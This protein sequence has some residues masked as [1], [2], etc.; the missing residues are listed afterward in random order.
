MWDEVERPVSNSLEYLRGIRFAL[1]DRDGVLNRKLPEGQFISKPGQLELLPDVSKAIRRLNDGG[2]RCLVLTNQRGIALGLYTE[3]DLEAIHKQL[4]SQ[5]GKRGARLDGFFHCPHDEGQCDCR[6]PK[7]GLLVQAFE[8]FPSA[9]RTNSVLIGDSLPDIQAGKNFGVRTIFV[10]GDP[11]SQKEGAS[12]AA[13]LADRQASSLLD[14]VERL[15]L[16]V[17]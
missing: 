15:L 9:S 4:R 14:A 17:T 13:A 3:R 6:K 8:A 2:I 11:G 1:L 12:Q 16:P 10:A 5:L 7:T